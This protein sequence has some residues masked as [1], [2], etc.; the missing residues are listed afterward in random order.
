[1]ILS[2]VDKIKI[3]AFA[4]FKNNI[5]ALIKFFQH[6]GLI[7]KKVF[8]CGY[9]CYNLVVNNRFPDK[10]AFRCRIGREFTTIRKGTYFE[11]SKLSLY[12][13]LM[14]MVYY[15]EGVTKQDFLKKQL[16][17][18]SN[19][20]IVDWKNFI[21][22]LF[23]DYQISHSSLIGGSGVVVQIDESL[24]CKRKYGVGRILANQDLWIV[25]GIDENGNIFMELTTRRTKPILREIINR[26]VV[27]GSIVVTDGWGGYNGI[28]DQYIREIV[29]HE[30]SFVNSDGY[31]TNRIEA[32]WG[33]CKRLLRNNTN[34]KRELIF[35]YI[36]EYMFRK[37][38]KGSVLSNMITVIM[39]MYSLPQND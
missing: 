23:I 15:A 29:I 10:Y 9:W 34:K 35:S 22:D 39:E 11:N 31:H 14:L 20:T 37:K 5:Y 3:D 12:H 6:F 18:D 4:A 7:P 33:A 19:S 25:G 32:T 16:D 26:H 21:R 30:N 38:F 27:P 2:D 8:C 24:I 13:I 1:M 17:I 36:C 28:D